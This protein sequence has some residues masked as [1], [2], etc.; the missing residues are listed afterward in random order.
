MISKQETLN[1]LVADWNEVQA[2]YLSRLLNLLHFN[3]DRTYSGKNV[4][5]ILE[6]TDYDIVFLNHWMPDMNGQEI[7]KAIR[8]LREDGKP[9]I[10]IMAPTAS[11]E[12]TKKYKGAGANKVFAKPLKMERFLHDLR[13]YFPELSLFITDNKKDGNNYHWSRIRLAFSDVKEINI[14]TGIHS[15]L[16]NYSIFIQ[17]MKSIYQ[18]LSLFVSMVSGHTEPEEYTDLRQRLHNLKSVFAYIGAEKLLEHTKGI[19]AG[20]K[21]EHYE[22]VI[23]QLEGFTS[24]LELFLNNMK[25]ALDNYNY[26]TELQD[27]EIDMFLQHNLGESYEQCIQKTIYYIKRFEY[28]LILH[29]LY[30]LIYRKNPDQQVFLKAAEEIRNF[31]YEGALE[32][33][34]Q[35]INRKDE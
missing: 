19:E 32:C 29:E 35:I 9:V 15:C 11:E 23:P 6:K 3:T 20:L 17:M 10:Y 30:K 1:I 21:E 31:N 2:M 12:L 28:D 14:D 27:G 33:I 16:G 5:Q 22:V 18:E 25:T 8:K 26:L 34:Y 7:T 24:Q 4:I 13:L